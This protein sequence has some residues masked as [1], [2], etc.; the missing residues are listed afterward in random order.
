MKCKFSFNK[1]YFGINRGIGDGE[2]I[3]IMWTAGPSSLP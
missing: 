2:K 3:R 1:K